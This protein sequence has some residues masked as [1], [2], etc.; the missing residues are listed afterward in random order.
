MVQKVIYDSTLSVYQAHSKQKKKN[1][2]QLT[3]IAVREQSI[4]KTEVENI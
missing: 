2:Q 3:E 4:F 1:K